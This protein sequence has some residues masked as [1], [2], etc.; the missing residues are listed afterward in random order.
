GKW[1]V[2]GLRHHRPDPSRI[3]LTSTLPLKRGKIQ[4]PLLPPGPQAE[5]ARAAA[6][7]THGPSKPPL[8]RGQLPGHQDAAKDRQPAWATPPPRSSKRELA[9]HAG[10][11]LAIASTSRCCSASLLPPAA[12][13]S[14][15]LLPH[16][17]PNPLP[18][19]W[20]AAPP[21]SSSVSIP[22]LMAQAPVPTIPP[23]FSSFSSAPGAIPSESLP[24]L[25]T[26]APM[27]AIPPLFLS[28]SSVPGDIRSVSMP[29]LA[30]P[31][32]TFPPPQTHTPF[33]LASATPLPVPPNAPALEPPPVPSSIRTQ[34]LAEIQIA[35]TK[36]DPLSTP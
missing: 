10:G 3:S 16:H 33:S 14:S 19:P 36:A 21:S 8:L 13:S 26:Q 30:V 17:S 4:T 7:P 18:N 6:L 25:M 22:P 23:L 11:E 1:T 15:Q 2:A 35:G 27:P 5:H 32:A 24:P 28:L 34:I 29:P 12:K 20:P 31:A 9:A